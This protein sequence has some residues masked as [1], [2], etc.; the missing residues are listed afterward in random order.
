MQTITNKLPKKDKIDKWLWNGAKDEVFT[1]KSTYNTIKRG[2]KYRGV[3]VGDL[4]CVMYKEKEEIISNLFFNCV[5]IPN[6]KW[7]LSLTQ[8]Y[9][10]NF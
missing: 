5:R 2:S 3:V 10:T 1:V 7:T 9:K 8:L 4:R 6:Q